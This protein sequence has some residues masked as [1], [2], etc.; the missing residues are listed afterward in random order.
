VTDCYEHGNEPSGPVNGGEFLEQLSIVL[1]SQ[2]G[3]SLWG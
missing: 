3:L 2:E 1:T